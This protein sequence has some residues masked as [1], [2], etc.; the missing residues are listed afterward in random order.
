MSKTRFSVCEISVVNN[1]I[2]EI[3]ITLK[4][5]ILRISTSDLWGHK[6]TVRIF[7]P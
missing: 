7:D 3:I 1:K 2:E 6:S 4:K 5:N